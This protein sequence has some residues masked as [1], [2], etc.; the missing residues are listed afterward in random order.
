MKML[1]RFFSLMNGS[2]KVGNIDSGDGNSTDGL[3][4]YRAFG[5]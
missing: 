3:V 2:F 5:W 4:G 1:A